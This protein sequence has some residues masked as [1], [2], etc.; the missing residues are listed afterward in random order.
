MQLKFKIDN[1]SDYF[2]AEAP[3]TQFKKVLDYT[4]TNIPLK[5]YYGVLVY[6]RQAFYLSPV[7]ISN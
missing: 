5:S 6:D 4:S 7:N 1:E 2:D 3:E